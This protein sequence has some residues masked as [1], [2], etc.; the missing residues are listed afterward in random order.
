MCVS[1]LQQKLKGERTGGGKKLNTITKKNYNFI[2]YGCLDQ[3]YKSVIKRSTYA[4]GIQS[5]SARLFY[6]IKT[7][8]NCLCV[9]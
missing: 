8:L 5:L 1:V 7:F 3:G 9:L 4:A 2:N 6:G